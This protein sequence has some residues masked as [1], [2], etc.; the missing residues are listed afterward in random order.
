MVSKVDWFAIRQMSNLLRKLG[1]E[2]AV[3]LHTVTDED[4]SEVLI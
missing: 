4:G 3:K 2:K 1:I